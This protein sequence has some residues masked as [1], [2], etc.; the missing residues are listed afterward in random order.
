MFIKLSVNLK[1]DIMNIVDVRHKT[2]DSIEDIPD[3]VYK[4][5]DW[6]NEL[7]KTIITERR[8]ILQLQLLL[9]ILWIVK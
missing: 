6:G 9:K 4:Y 7:H 1:Y 5:R 8:F 2:I 3:I